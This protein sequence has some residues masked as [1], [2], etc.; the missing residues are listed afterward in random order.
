[1]VSV[2][3]RDA[4]AN[5]STLLRLEGFDVSVA[6]DGPGA[7]ELAASLRPEIAVVDLALPGLDGYEVGRRLR[8]LL[9]NLLLSSV[10]AWHVDADR[11]REAG[12]NHLLGK[13][14][15]VTQFKQILLNS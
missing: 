9:T 11:A 7:L 6:Y 8:Q 15:E 12:F 13:P 10:S 5:L 2:G 3:D 1:M 4:V 14:F